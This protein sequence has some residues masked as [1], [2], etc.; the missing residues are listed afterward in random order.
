[1]LGVFY[2]VEAEWENLWIK[3]NVCFRKNEF[4]AFLKYLS[5]FNCLSPEG[6]TKAGSNPY[7]ITLALH[8]LQIST[9]KLPVNHLFFL[10]V[11][12]EE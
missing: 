7:G 12:V 3:N 6:K 8:V 10:V 1:M 4:L 9:Q 5:E 11:D 2:F